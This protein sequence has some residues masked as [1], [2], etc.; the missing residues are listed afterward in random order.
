MITPGAIPQIVG[1]LDACSSHGFMVSVL[2]S[3]F[4]DTGSAVMQAWSGLSGSY[5][6]PESEVLFQ[7]MVPVAFTAG[8]VG[9]RRPRVG[10]ERAIAPSVRSGR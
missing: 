9:P 1:D 2:G 8:S 4:A 3:R 10:L 7:A 6:A 5:V